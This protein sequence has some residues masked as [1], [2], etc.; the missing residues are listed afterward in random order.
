MTAVVELAQTRKLIPRWIGHGDLT[1]VVDGAVYARADQVEQLAGI[2]PWSGGETL[3]GD[4]WAR[5]IDGQA[6]YDLD[7]AIARCEAAG[8]AQATEFLDWLRTTIE[9]LLTDEVLDLAHRAPAFIGSYPVALAARIL[10]DDPAI[11][12]G[13][14][15]LFAHL[16][17]IGWI[18]RAGTD[19]AMTNL[20][21]RNGWLTV[22]DVT[23]PAANRAHR[24]TYPQLHVTPDGLH[25]LARTLHALHPDRAP[26][27]PPHPQLFD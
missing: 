1:I 16:E 17:H 14:H 19:W 23:I 5:E 11:T 4:T 21:R 24:R 6:Y 27:R 18:E 15:G 13:Q 12:I 3:L 2:R 20:A 8:T 26:E 25:H 22:R 10:S 9:Q 7:D